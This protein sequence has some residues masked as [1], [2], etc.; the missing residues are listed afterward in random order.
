MDSQSPARVS[1]RKTDFRS[2]TDSSNTYIKKK[3]AFQNN[4]TSN[5]LSEWIPALE[6]AIEN[7]K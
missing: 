1:K 2:V 7:D 6:G 3:S 5:L 4:K